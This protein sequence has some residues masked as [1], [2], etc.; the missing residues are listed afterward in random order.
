[1]GM[2]LNDLLGQLGCVLR[3]GFKGFV[4]PKGGEYVQVLE[5]DCAKGMTT[6]CLHVHMCRDS[7]C[8]CVRV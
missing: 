1:V 6:E 3:L 5:S 7:V 2:G 4:L 8:Q